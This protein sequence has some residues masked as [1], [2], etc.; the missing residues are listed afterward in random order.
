MD[1]VTRIDV[2]NLDADGN[3]VCTTFKFPKDLVSEKVWD[4]SYNAATQTFYGLVR[5]AQ[6]GADAQLFQIDISEVA[7]GG[8]PSF[9][10]TPVTATYVDGV[11]LEGAP[12]MTFGAFMVDGDGNLYAGGNG[13]D[14]DM[15]D[16]TGISGG[17][18][19]VETDP[20]TG[21]LCLV[22]AAD[23]P[24]SYSNDG[25]IDP[26]TMDPFTETDVNAAVLIRSPEMTEAPQAE[27]SY[28]D[29]I[30]AGA[31]AD[32]VSGGFGDDLLIG[33]SA[34]DSIY[35]DIGN[36]TLDG[37]AGPGWTDNGLRSVYDADGTRRDQFGNLLPEDDDILF[38]GLGGDL[39]NGSAGHDT[40]DGGLGDDV[41]QG[42]SGF[43]VL[44]GGEGNDDLSGGSGTDH[45]LGGDGNDLLA[46]GGS[47]DTL[48]GGAGSDTLEGGSDSDSLSGGTGD[49][50]LSGG[51]GSDEME[52]DAGDDLLTGGSGDDTMAGG[53]GNDTLLGGSGGDSLTGGTGSDSL[54]GGSGED[55]LHGGEGNDALNG[56]SGGDVLSG[57]DGKDYLNGS[58]GDDILDGG[59]GRDRIYLG[60]GDDTAAGG[61]GSD[62]FI[63]RSEDLDGSADEITDFT[64]N[65]S[66]NDS[67]DL[68]QLNLLEDGG[69]AAAWAEAH[70][71]Y[72]AGEGVL[73]QLGDWE[74]TLADH[75]AL[76]TAY[77]DTV[78]D[79]LL[80]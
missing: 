45:L 74:L 36:D 55:Q 16:A 80:L 18:Y 3:P 9:S 43:D 68:R 1:H 65:G 15:N 40:L 57:G 24:R 5:P 79:G 44:Y 69:D 73:L 22:L 38:G 32:T 26:R 27:Q 19:R 59:S 29:S 53:Q 6:E 56:G 76:G 64:R 70:L 41:L 7:G 17:I 35:G 78:T 67:L 46:G 54:K 72:A 10:M 48:E 21:E 51:S 23:A 4:V 28:D 50:S 77:L 71:S 13:G 12:A 66:E 20:Q 11:R 8:E 61:G 33:S 63:F 42:G 60:A 30:S 25:A 47:S 58:S 62:V 2:D 52:G 49:D 37:G 31:G 39:L 34:G 75:Q 14:H